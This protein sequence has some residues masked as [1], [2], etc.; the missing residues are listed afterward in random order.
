MERKTGLKLLSTKS[1]ERVD[2]LGATLLLGTIILLVTGF[3]EAGTNRPWRSS[4][5][6]S[7]LTISGLLGIAFFL[8]ERKETKADGIREPIF[9][10]NLVLSRIWM[11][12]VL[13]VPNV[14]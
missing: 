12:T 14:I 9:P 8:W 2:F 4:V 6:I 13:Y 11:G 5:V 10:W 3:E 1:L 7:L